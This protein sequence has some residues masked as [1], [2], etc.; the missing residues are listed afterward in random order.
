MKTTSTFLFALFM[1]TIA[2]AQSP[3]QFNYQAVAR[4]AGGDVLTGTL[5]LRFSLLEDLDN[6]TVRY[7]ETHTVTT[8]AQGVF[9]VH[10]GDGIA[11]NGDI[12]NVNWGTHQ[13]FL[14][15]EL[16]SPGEANYTTMGT[17]KLLS[18]PYAM[19]A[20]ASGSELQGGEGIDIA[21]G[22]ATNTGDLSN[23]NELQ[24]LSLIG[25]Q[26]AISNGNAVNL[27][28]GTAYTEGQGIDI[29]N[30]IIANTGDLSNTNE[31][32]SLQ[33]QGQQLSISNGNTITLPINTYN[34]G[35][36]IDIN[37][38]MISAEDSSP[39]N[40][41]Q[42]LNVTGQQLT[43][44]NG[45][46]VNLPQP[47]PYNAGSGININN[48]VVSA[49]DASATNEIQALSLN[50]Q[51][52][53]LS[54]GGGSVTLPTST[55]NWSL[56]G[57]VVSLNPT[58]YRVAI[59]ETSNGNS[60]LLVKGVQAE[61]AGTFVTEQGD[62]GYFTSTNGNALLVAQ[63]NVGIGN[64]LPTHK[65]DVLGT[66]YLTSNSGPSL[67]IGN[68]K[69]G[70]GTENPTTK[71]TVDA[72][73]DFGIRVISD[74]LTAID[75]HGHGDWVTASFYSDEGIAGYFSAQN[76]VCI[77]A[78]QGAYGTAAENQGIRLSSIGA[79]WKTYIDSPKDYNFACN[80]VL[81]AWIWD[82]D[83]SYHNSSDRSL[84]KN[85]NSFSNVLPKLTQ[86]QAYTYHMRDASD[87][88]P[89][90]VGFMAQDV[91]NV[92]PE[93]VTEKEGYKSL[94]YDHFA[95]LSVEAIKE[96]QVIIEDLTARITA[97]EQVIAKLT[98]A[99]GK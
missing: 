61:H 48:H 51:Q 31:L 27:P 55:T 92:F 45:N 64:T 70:I 24:T 83:G 35:A 69:V 98:P 6:G 18:V 57:S 52:L 90:S 7:I 97:L 30:G 34:A 89:I 1:C 41:L 78:H 82:T 87:D 12:S 96:Q 72:G 91:E 68:G 73:D 5:Q 43:I 76:N 49:V 95:V 86:L 19:Y 54:N 2:L 66:T 28:A 23:E 21:N 3:A 40:E 11:V 44:S 22:I 63:G 17:S 85:I 8:D 93:L 79:T 75:A 65:L 32:Q 42:T 13:Y 25:N 94:C 99:A 37:G 38:T 4:N 67:L 56:N 74:N 9:A 15:T 71:L 29:N 26:L 16:K 14:K 58:N 80:N 47:T 10:I 81:K 46:T 60:K 39:T 20:A 88:S 62:A 36:G 53:S 84:K 33:L 59:G 77:D 50:G